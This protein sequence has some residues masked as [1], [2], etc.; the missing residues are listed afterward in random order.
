MIV[1]CI[2][3]V[4]LWGFLTVPTLSKYSMRTKHLFSHIL[5]YNFS[6]EC[7]I[8]PLLKIYGIKLRNIIEVGIYSVINCVWASVT[9]SAAML[10]V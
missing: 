5:A 4:L 9:R 7:V 10:K 3:N 6:Y 8:T 1:C 2:L